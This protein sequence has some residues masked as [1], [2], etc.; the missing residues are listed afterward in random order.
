MQQKG[1]IT[2][3]F[4]VF[5]TLGLYGQQL[6]LEGLPAQKSFQSESISRQFREFSVFQIDASQLA[7]HARAHQNA[8][9]HLSLGI[10]Y[11][12]HFVIHPNQ[13]VD[14][15][16]V[17]RVWDGQKE[18]TKRL[19]KQLTFDGQLE[20]EPA[21][22]VR[23]TLDDQFIYGFFE[24]EAE[25]VFIEPLS[26]FVPGADPN[27]FIVYR[28]SDVI[29][30]EHATCG[31][32][33]MHRKSEELKHQPRPEGGKGTP[34]TGNCYELDLAIASDF[35]MFVKYG[36][37][38]N[39]E[40]H[41]IGV[42]NNV[43]ANYDN[44]FA[45]EI[46]FVIVEQFVS[47]CSSCDPWTSSTNPNTLL[48]S[49][50][51][52]GP[53]GFNQ[54]HDLGQL[55]TNRDFDGGVV[56]IA[57]L[58]A[59]CTNNRYHAIQDFTNNASLIRMT[60]AH[61]IGHNFNCIHDGGPLI[62]IMSPTV[63][64]TDNWSTLSIN[65]VNSYVNSL[66][67]QGGCLTSCG[68]ALPPVA[69]FSA[70]LTDLCL[71]TQTQFY[72]L[73]ENSPTSWN[74][75]FP[76]GSPSG[77]TDQN[78]LVTYNVPGTYPV[79]LTASNGV[80][81]DVVTFS[82]YITVGAA[83]EDMILFEDFE[84]NLGAW[85]VENPDN[86]NGWEYY[87]TQGTRFGT[88]VAR[89]ENFSYGTSS[90]GRKDAL[91]SPAFSL[92]GHEV[93]RVEIDYA[94]ARYNST[95]KDSLNIY[96]SLDGGNTFPVKLFGN[97]ENGNGNFATTPD[98]TTAFDPISQEDWCLAG[99][100]GAGCLSVDMS[101]YGGEENVV[102][103]LENVSGNGNNLYVDNVRVIASC[104]IPAPIAAFQ[105][106]PNLGC[107][108]MIVNFED[109]STGNPAAWDWQFPGGTPTSSTDQFPIITYNSTGT[110]DVTLT[111]SN[112][113]GSSTSVI[114]N[115]ITVLDEPTTAFTY[116]EA[117]A[118]VTFNN[119]S[120]GATQ[121]LWDFGDGTTSTQV[122]PVH[123]YPGDG[124]Y[125]VT[126]TATN[127]CGST[128]FQQTI[129]I[130]TPPVA[131]FSADPLFGCTP[132]VVQFTDESST[133]TTAWQWSFPGGTPSSSTEQNPVV[134][135]SQAGSFDVTLTVINGAGSN[136]FTETDLILAVDPPQA[137]FSINQNGGVVSLTN[138]SDNAETYQW[139]FGDGQGSSEIN[140]VHTYNDDGFYTIFLVSNS[141]FCGTDTAQ[142]LVEVI[143]L[144]EAG[145]SADST[146]GCEPLT[147]IFSNESSDNADS[148]SWFFPGGQPATAS[149]N[150]P[151][152]LYPVAGTF[153]VILIALN[154]NGSDTMHLPAFIQV[155]PQPVAAFDVAEN[156]Q[157]VSFTN[158]STEATAYLWDF[159]DGIT[160][161]EMDPVH[162]YGQDG[163][164]LVTLVSSN[165]CGADTA[166]QQITLLTQPEADFFADP[167]N[168]CVP[169]SV[170]FSNESSDNVDSLR[171]LF[172]GGIPASS[173]MDNPTVVY[174][175]AGT[176]DVSLI[177]Y[178]ALGAD[179][180][181]RLGY[182]QTSAVPDA[183]FT[184]AINGLEV[185][186]TNTSSSADSWLWTFGNGQ[187]SSAF[188][189]TIIYDAE[190]TYSVSLVA[191]NTCG[192][193]TASLEVLLTLSPVA[194]A[195]A[196]VQ[197]GC[198]GTTIQ[199]E[200]QSSG[201][202]ETYAWAF[203]GGD[204]ESSA[205]SDPVVTYANPGIYDVILVVSNTVGSDTLTLE[206]YIVIDSLPVA[207]FSS[208]VT[209]ET[210]LFNNTSQNAVSWSWDFG[211]GNGSVEEN[212]VYT[213]EAEGTYQ[214]TL[215]ATGSCGADTSIQDVVIIFPPVANFSGDILTG[216]AGLAVQFTSEASDNTTS[217]AW[218][219]PG[220]QPASSTE[221][222]PV[223]TYA[224][225]GTYDV[226]LIVTNSVG[227]DTL[228]LENYLTI[229]ELPLAGFQY[230]LVAGTATFQNTSD[231]ADTY[232]WQ[233]GDGEM[234]NQFAPTHTYAEDG[235]Y[236][237]VL[238]ASGACGSDT[239]TMGLQVV[240]PPVAGFGSDVVSA[241]PGSEI[242]FSDQSTG[243][244]TSW[245]W[246]FPGGTPATSTQQSPVVVYSATGAYDVTLIVAN[247][248]GSDTLTET[249]YISILSEPVASF[250]VVTNGLEA[251]FTNNSAAADGWQWYFGDG[252]TSTSFEPTHIYPADGL[253]EVLLVAT[254]D[255]GADTS[256]Q[257]L[258]IQ[259]PPVAGFIATPTTI[260]PGETV[261]F[262]NQSS[263][264]AEFFNWYF[265]GG[266]PETS[267]EENPQVAY[268][269]EGLYDVILIAGN[270]AGTDTIQFTQFIE[271]LPLPF[272]QFNPAVNGMQVDFVNLSSNADSYFWSFG[273]GAV[274]TETNP[275]HTYSEGGIYV[276]E[277]WAINTCDSALSSAFITILDPPAAS[278]KANSTSGCAPYPI[279]FVDLSQGV[280]E[281]WYWEFPGGNPSSSTQQN[282]VVIYDVAGGYDV[283]L[284][285]SNASGSDTLAQT[286]YV[287]IS[288]VPDPGFSF[289]ANGLQV[290][291]TNESEGAASYTWN[292]GD[293]SGSSQANPV[294]EYDS[295]GTYVVT[296]FAFNDCGTISVSDS[297][298]VAVPPTAF[299]EVNPDS[300]VCVPAIIQLTDLSTNNPTSWQWTV[301]GPELFTSTEQNPSF[302]I[303]L[304]GSYVI[305]LEA[306]NDVGSTLYFI[307]LD[308][309]QAPLAG[310]DFTSSDLQVAF[311]SNA[312]NADSYSWQFGDGNGSTEAS[313]THLYDDYGSYNVL[314]VVKNSCGT[315]SATATVVL[316]EP[317]FVPVAAF[318]ADVLSGCPPLEVHFSDSSLNEPTL[319]EWSFPGGTPTASADPNPVVVYEDEGVYDVRLVV[320]NAAGSDTLVWPGYIQVDSL[321]EAAFTW[322]Q[323]DGVV[324]FDNSSQHADTYLWTFG[325]N[326]ESTEENPI[327][328]YSESG[329]FVVTLIASNDCGA[330]TVS[331]QLEII[332]INTEQPLFIEDFR[333]YPN[334]GSG[335]VYLEMGGQPRPEVQFD[336]FD[337]L[338]RRIYRQ[339]ENFQSGSLKTFFDWTHLPSATYILEVNS[340][341]E[342]GR[343][344]II[345][346]R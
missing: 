24:T 192:F 34:E 309:G 141:T 182:V 291:F 27:L 218:S 62:W 233:F 42:M 143:T 109:L 29:D 272:S 259:T 238:I 89:M 95:R 66:V 82:S 71:G 243:Q 178:N 166:V 99:T 104:E 91:I 132:L 247:S 133:N 282:P 205:A 40:N 198:P 64:N 346:E 122:N 301:D 127:D 206:N 212:P 19:N 188:D 135:Y 189:T 219:F 311:T 160:S 72:D 144:P 47:T 222:N 140:P 288:D 41:T 283:T 138:E 171:W 251:V 139:F 325:D 217:W 242:V 125:T 154:D 215:V 229:N 75:S 63:N 305:S 228:V 292:F 184:T 31:V 116:T 92:L 274:S 235:F 1:Y 18:V 320:S 319:W 8:Q 187:Q 333:L 177:V 230:S 287:T 165:A 175:N 253:Y 43:Q 6:F 315:D 199:F 216:C 195:G 53:S 318:S 149:D 207:D 308:A 68:V 147:V 14:P 344:K 126:L 131:A 307:T 298:E 48:S 296:L 98:Q 280:V 345:I 234:S 39:V 277:L 54:V 239:L 224:T 46:Q 314:L 176:Y 209:V 226:S 61:E 203:P 343:W 180:L 30:P 278:F 162:D 281:S 273:D 148:L 37:V 240:L 145:F 275:T 190:G 153:D 123:S 336:L 101:Q 151:I 223:I 124:T 295:A 80:G 44:E 77:S 70:L 45:D 227:S 340:G 328:E 211:D 59:V 121:Y 114:P 52:W 179:T 289:S 322:D 284:I 269:N 106:S 202:V 258:T 32:G 285:V 129:T 155:D 341:N 159:G 150:N 156:G 220:G 84:G 326:A 316:E 117:D 252:D 137:G 197:N 249:A 327:H 33:D 87:V 335:A 83:G 118:V 78:P 339:Q 22:E 208:T 186:F 15:N 299:F 237:V 213:Y 290:T 323:Q 221:E 4:S 167:T 90:I 310:F 67:N 38:A 158:N 257:I 111:V 96:L 108:P 302:T 245:T 112:V 88:G 276:V 97:T 142:A 193:D 49:F 10:N 57:W 74:W 321:P 324:A 164:Y 134:T 103:K 94:Y 119:Q 279:Q 152:V 306:S 157:V 342:S 168:G 81:S 334:P 20:G 338:G 3:L 246:S 110:F 329:E 163:N 304:P 73:S 79:T 136:T 196:D 330:D 264:N 107:I 25:V 130:I 76:G 17:M 262:D 2:L 16:Y 115:Y 236:T 9:V 260:C 200:D 50:T 312:T 248:E 183:G 210:V 267:Q 23:L 113:G 254:S 225:P 21:S 146:Q 185:V 331:G 36:S 194:G 56:G 201:T 69:N 268:F 256:M 161:A 244:V 241:C 28:A 26:F 172:P 173:T 7:E 270:G 294:H 35:L 65:T 12:W 85:Q 266:F 204:P 303:N 100:F 317:V 250:E 5:L 255:C 128:F 231:N 93:S 55:W 191:G 169:L 300:F 232:S 332:L 51:N 86:A 313:P 297:I 286:G 293:G 170:S 261:V 263:D 120:T 11:D 105:G 265:P 58:G 174:E 271:A 337:M 60:V 13:T 214:V 181:T 102:L